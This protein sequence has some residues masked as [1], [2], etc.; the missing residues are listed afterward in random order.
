[1][2]ERDVFLPVAAQPSV[3]ALVEQARLGE[4][5]GYEAAWPHDSGS[6]AVS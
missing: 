1:M 6:Q 4:E 3:D 2:T 5:L